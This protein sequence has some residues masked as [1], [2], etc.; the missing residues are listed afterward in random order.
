MN[1]EK[2]TELSRKFQTSE[3]YDGKYKV[4]FMS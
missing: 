4:I 1:E 3:T 2:V